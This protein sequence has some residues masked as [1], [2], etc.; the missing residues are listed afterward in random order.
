MAWPGGHKRK[1]PPL[2]TRK[3]Y[4]LPLASIITHDPLTR[5]CVYII[6]GSG[7]P[8][9]PVVPDHRLR[10]LDRYLIATYPIQPSYFLQDCLEDC[11]WHFTFHRR[12]FFLLVLAREL[13]M[14][15]RSV[16]A[17]SAVLRESRER[18]RQQGQR[19]P[20][21]AR[22]QHRLVP[23]RELKWSTDMRAGPR[24]PSVS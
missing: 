2:P 16:P 8:K 23:K 21:Q 20:I 15:L 22:P 18:K 24:R 7:Q 3:S 1:L 9:R 5:A 10:A 14:G 17:Q 13:R 12:G 4:L 6:P 11:L 19:R